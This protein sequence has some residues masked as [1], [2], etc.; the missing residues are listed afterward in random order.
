LGLYSLRNEIHQHI[1]LKAGGKTP[2]SKLVWI[3]SAVIINAGEGCLTE[4]IQTSV[5]V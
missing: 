5:T 1:L 2:W 4:N 3:Q